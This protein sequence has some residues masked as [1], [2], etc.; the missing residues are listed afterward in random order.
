MKIFLTKISGNSISPIQCFIENISVDVANNLQIHNSQNKKDSVILR[1]GNWSRSISV[2]IKTRDDLLE[3]DKERELY[4]LGLKTI[5]FYIDSFDKVKKT[6]EEN[7]IYFKLVKN[8][9]DKTEFDVDLFNNFIFEHLTVNA[10][11]NKPFLIRE[12]PI[13]LDEISYSVDV[14]TNFLNISLIGSFQFLSKA[15]N[16]SIENFL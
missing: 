10:S 6:G 9:E 4:E 14:N 11:E 13:F 2:V 1:T 15:T 5:K 7:K 16:I 3:N 12:L 8:L